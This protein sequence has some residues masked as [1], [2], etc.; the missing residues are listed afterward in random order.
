MLYSVQDSRYVCYECLCLV[1]NDAKSPMHLL[2]QQMEK[3]RDMSVFATPNNYFSQFVTRLF[4]DPVYLKVRK[5][6]DK[7]R[8]SGTAGVIK[9]QHTL[10]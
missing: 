4:L 5:T 3:C 10:V 6:L 2:A 1:H 8:A 7:L 9:R